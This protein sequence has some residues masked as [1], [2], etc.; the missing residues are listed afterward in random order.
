MAGCARTQA[1]G[2][3]SLCWSTGPLSEKTSTT[4]EDCFRRREREV[5]GALGWALGLW[6][7]GSGIHRRDSRM[8]SC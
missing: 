8:R 6:P 2:W 4:G 5:G 3:L 1:P 7:Q